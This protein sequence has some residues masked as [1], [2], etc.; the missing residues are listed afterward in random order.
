MC[1]CRYKVKRQGNQE[2]SRIQSEGEIKGNYHKNQDGKA[3]VIC[4]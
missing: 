2:V 4:I 1:V 3:R